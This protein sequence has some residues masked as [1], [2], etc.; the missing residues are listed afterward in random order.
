LSF[1]LRE[2]LAEVYH[3]GFRD[4]TGSLLEQNAGIGNRRDHIATQIGGLKRILDC[5]SCSVAIGQI[6]KAPKRSVST[7][8]GEKDAQDI[9]VLEEDNSPTRRSLTAEELFDSESTSTTIPTLSFPTP[10]GTKITPALSPF[11][12]SEHLE[13][14]SGWYYSDTLKSLRRA[15]DHLEHARIE[16]ISTQLLYFLEFPDTFYEAKIKDE[17]SE[18]YTDLRDLAELFNWKIYPYSKSLFS[19]DPLF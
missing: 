4:I 13:E 12:A 15:R 19:P 18:V 6:E 7:R 9:F 3:A 11:Q 2:S 5:V 14:S 10:P 17:I 8:I 16:A 1:D